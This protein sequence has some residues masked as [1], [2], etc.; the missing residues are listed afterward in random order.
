MT[1]SKINWN[2]L[3]LVGPAATFT[4]LFFLVPLVAMGV[5]SFTAGGALSLD[6]Y[7]HF[8]TQPSYVRAL[9][10]SLEVTLVVTAIS[11]V[12]AYPLAW[13][14]AERVPERWQR[15]ALMLTIL[16][17]WTSYVVRSYSWLLLLAERGIVNRAL[18]ASGLIDQ[19]LQLANTR[20]ATV[21]GFVHF[22]IMLL[23]LT[24]YA[25]FRQLSPSYRKAAA[26]LGAGG[27]QTFLYV[28][29]PL[30]LPGIMVG[31]FLAFVLAIGD[32]VTPQLLGGSNELLMPQLI[33]Q[34]I[35]RR[36]DLPLA[37]AL[38]L[39]LMVVISIAYLACARWLK[40]ERT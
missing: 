8:L 30:T 26:D 24:I 19:P 33:I 35:G 14:L 16:P 34:Q 9:V 23:T 11:V 1:G 17:F 12:V 2:T 20:T 40:L 38:S 25:N 13:V 6:N 21:I 10:N 39:I 4:V 37:A 5:A 18:M 28:V 15:V 27:L 3:W 7:R 22:F 36:A 32:Y 29:L 31:A